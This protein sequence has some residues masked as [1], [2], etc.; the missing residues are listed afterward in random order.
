MALSISLT[1]VSVLGIAAMLVFPT[2]S[3]NKKGYLNNLYWLFPLISLIILLATNTLPI[4]DYWSNLTANSQMNPL[5][6]LVLFL[7]LSFICVS[8]DE[9]G[10]FSFIAEK[11]TSKSGSS[12]WKLFFIIYG[13]VSLLTIFTSNDIVILTFTPFIIFYAKRAKIDPLPYLISEFVAANTWSLLFLI[14]NPTNIYLGASSNINLATYFVNMALPALTASL[15][16]LLILILIFHK[17]LKAPLSKIEV[18]KESKINDLPLAIASLI[19]LFIC[20]VLFVLSSWFTL[21]MWLTSGISALVLLLFSFIESCI[22]RWKDNSLLSSFKR[23]PYSVVPFVL[24]MFGLVMA[25]EETGVLS[26]LASFL[27]QM[28]TTFSYGISGFLFAGLINNLPMS[29]L[30]SRLLIVGQVNLKACYASIIASNL[31][32]FLTPLGALAGIMWMKILKRYDVKLSFLK[33]TF[34]GSLVGIPSLLLSLLV[35]FLM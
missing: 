33:F 3:L 15:T 13:M 11:A 31:G 18:T 22:K 8:L 6:I 29:V 2:N 17:K 35:L 26:Y 27:N 9:A 19:I 25:L 34:Y 32:A 12:Q 21:P 5:E 1:I 28:D 10:F 4:A 14:G 16:S 20:L 24:S 23:L 7:S 30:Y